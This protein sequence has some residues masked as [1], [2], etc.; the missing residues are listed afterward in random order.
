MKEI[1]TYNI[2]RVS[3]EETASTEMNDDTVKE[4]ETLAMRG[5]KSKQT[6]AGS[7]SLLSK[8]HSW[9]SICAEASNEIGNLGSA[10]TAKVPPGSNG[11]RNASE[12]TNGSLLAMLYSAP[13]S[14]TLDDSSDAAGI[15]IPFLKD[16]TTF[17]NDSEEDLIDI[18]GSQSTFRNEG[19]IVIG[20]SSLF[21]HVFSASPTTTT[22]SPSWDEEIRDS[23]ESS[24]KND[25]SS[26]A[27]IPPQDDWQ[28]REMKTELRG[29]WSTQEEWDSLFESNKGSVSQVFEEASPA[30][31]VFT[32][33][34]VTATEAV[35]K[36]AT[37][38]IELSVTPTDAL[39]NGVAFVLA[40]KTSSFERS[41]NEH[42]PH[43][44]Y[45]PKPQRD[46]RDEQ[47]ANSTP[48]GRERRGD[49]TKHIRVTV[50][51]PGD[52][53]KEISVLHTNLSWRCLK[54]T[55]RR[56]G[57]VA[58]S[59]AKTAPRSRKYNRAYLA[60]KDQVPLYHPTWERALDAF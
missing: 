27:V 52:T 46:Q 38:G 32:E 31:N 39:T 16:F 8:H 28:E 1:R 6:T 36:E 4:T 9:R 55:K 49:F 14:S 11:D 7:A 29:T 23:P 37:E 51:G 5:E 35:A 26:S 42:T 34:I 13:I 50:V 10:S 54:K 57:V 58:E 25:K 40:Q 33:P 2:W 56:N 53:P 21:D 48:V 3:N 30:T 19:G 20:N 12:T 43:R 17:D 18:K 59:G 15:P 44:D 45:F 47:C 24:Q 22:V 60:A 41:D